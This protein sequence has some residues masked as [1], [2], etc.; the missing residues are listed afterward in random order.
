M[1]ISVI[2]ANEITPELTEKWVDIQNENEILHS[3]FLT[4][5]YNFLV[6]TVKADVFIAILENN[7]KIVG[8]F[9]FEKKDKTSGEPVGKGVTDYQAVIIKKNTPI[10]VAKLITKCGLNSWEFDHLLMSQEMFKPYY[11]FETISPIIDLSKGYEHYKTERRCSGTEQIIQIEKQINKIEKEVGKIC[12]T[13]SI[14]DIE[15]LKKLTNW[16][17]AQFKRTGVFDDFSIVWVRDL[18][19]KIFYFEKRIDFSILLSVIFLEDKP[20][21]IEIGLRYKSVNHGWTSAYDI[22]YSKYSP[23]LILQ[24]KIIENSNSIG[25]TRIDLGK[26]T[27]LYKIRIMNNSIQIAEGIVNLVTN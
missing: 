9:P 15:M 20:I 10:D 22:N 12:F 17:S 5:Y 24:L 16:K 26:G 14:M 1:K 19:E 23:G 18:Y 21:A 25:I 27:Y 7:N 3:P 4:P 11:T 2:K 6:S 8:F 13:Q